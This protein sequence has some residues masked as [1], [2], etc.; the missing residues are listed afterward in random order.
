MYLLL[1]EKDNHN[2]TSDYL[3]EIH[4]VGSLN[5][6]LMSINNVI[7]LSNYVVT[8][9]NIVSYNLLYDLRFMVVIFSL[10]FLIP[11]FILVFLLLSIQFIK[12]LISYHF[13]SL[14]DNSIQIVCN[15]IQYFY[16]KEMNFHKINQKNSS[17]NQ[18]IIH[19]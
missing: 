5:I 14:I 1:V 6:I 16:S 15:V 9:T 3:K 8:S 18:L 13:F 2:M 10:A 4:L 11:F 12:T 17:I 19:P 7:V